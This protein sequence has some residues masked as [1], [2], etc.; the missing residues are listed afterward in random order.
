MFCSPFGLRTEISTRYCL[1]IDRNCVPRLFYVYEKVWISYGKSLLEIIFHGGN[2][3]S[4]VGN[5]FSPREALHLW[6][7]GHFA[8]PAAS[9]DPTDPSIKGGGPSALPFVEGSLWMG[10]LSMAP[11]QG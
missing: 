7:Y 6:I 10:P 11:L 1:E 5:Y 9:A 8:A 4:T 2:Y 3:F